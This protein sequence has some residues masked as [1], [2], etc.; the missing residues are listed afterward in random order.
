[1]R[2]APLASLLLSATL[3]AQTPPQQRGVFVDDVDRS[4]DACANFF[5]FANGAWRKANPIPASMQR[6]SRRWASG[7]LSKEQLR[8]I[9]DD[10]SKRH[11]WPKGSI[12][13]QITDFYGS[14]MDEKRVNELGTKPIEPLLSDIDAH[15]VV[16]RHA[17][18]DHTPAR[19]AVR[20]AVRGPVS[21]GQSQSHRR[22]RHASSPPA[23][24]SPIA[25]TTSTPK[26]ASSKRARSISSTSPK[27]SS[28]PARRKRRPRKPRRPSSISRSRLAKAHLTN[29][30]LRDPKLTDHKTTIAALQ[31]MT[32][33]FD[34][35]ALSRHAPASRPPISM[36][37]S[38]KFM[39][40]RGERAVHDA[41]RRV[42]NV[43]E[44]ERDQRLRAVALR[45]ARQ[46]G[47][48]VLQPV[49]ARRRRR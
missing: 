39:E 7:E 25:I 14:C 8:A 19:A 28:S 40:S 12:D 49:S 9:L 24:A 35:K 10:L 30:E 21:A 4:A 6:W 27:C 3:L 32:P 47:L 5:D 15:Q 23:S 48:R 45:A 11:D 1:M 44:V 2:I 34:W 33:H 41:A 22:D 26:S 38:R 29:V 18:D 13:Q 16:R 43:P 17:G 46:A 31:K 42:E 36:S 37:I 20:G